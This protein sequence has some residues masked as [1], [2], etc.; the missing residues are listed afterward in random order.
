ML[1]ITIFGA[2]LQW[3]IGFLS[4]RIDRR[5]ILVGTTLL[6][7]G[8]C[9]FIVISSYLSLTIFFIILALYSG[10]SLPLYSLAIAHINEFLQPDEIV[11]AVAS[12]AILVGIGAILGPIV[13]S[14]FMSI[15][16]A[17]GFFIY[18]FI[19]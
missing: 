16:G 2:L 1:I 4:D 3:P 6:A 15:I 9:I 18:L 13:V 19:N 17:D 5:I 12:F 7:S 14:V 10:M 8:A 11:T